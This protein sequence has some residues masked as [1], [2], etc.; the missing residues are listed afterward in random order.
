[1][2]KVILYLTGWHRFNPA[3][4]RD[5]RR[6]VASKREIEAEERR[7]KRLGVEEDRAEEAREAQ[8]ASLKA[9]RKEKAG[10]ARKGA[11]AFLDD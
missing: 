10:R 8:R 1:M 2:Q 6:M 7:S 11:A 9:A 5:D 3:D 4:D